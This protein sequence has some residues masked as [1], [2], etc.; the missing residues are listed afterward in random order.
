M[1]YSCL[2]NLQ[3]IHALST[4]TFSI[5]RENSFLVRNEKGGYSLYNEK[6]FII[7]LEIIKG[8]MLELNIYDTLEE[9]MKHEK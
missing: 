5:N 3:S 7:E 8:E 6:N 4:L 2:C 9:A 1:S